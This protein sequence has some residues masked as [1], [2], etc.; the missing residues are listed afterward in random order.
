MTAKFRI[1]TPRACD[2]GRPI[3]A[4]LFSLPR[5]WPVCVLTSETS[6]SLPTRLRNHLQHPSTTY[7]LTPEPSKL[8]EDAVDVCIVGGGSAG[9][10]D[11][12]R[13]KPLK[14]ETGNETHSS[15]EWRT[16]YPDHPLARPVTSSGMRFLVEYY[17][18][19]I[20]HP[21][22]M[23]N[24]A[25]YITSPSSVVAWLGDIREEM[26]VEL[27]AKDAPGRCGDA[28]REA[29]APAHEG[30]ALPFRARATL[31][32][33]GVRASLS[34]HAVATRMYALKHEKV[35]QMYGMKEAWRVEEEKHVPGCTKHDSTSAP[36]LRTTPAS[37]TARALT[38]GGLPRL[39][40]PSGALVGCAAGV[41]N[42]AK[43]KGTHDAM[44]TRMLDTPSVTTYKE[45]VQRLQ[46]MRDIMRDIAKC[47]KEVE[48]IRTKTLRI[49]EAER[50]HQFS[51]GIQESREIIDGATTFS[52][53]RL[54]SA[55]R[56]GYQSAVTR[57]T[58]YESM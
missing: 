34:K 50:Q 8:E 3:P 7:D 55:R 45:F 17:L 37:P 40:F 22:Q 30:V 23:H 16:A 47:T 57:N 2:R 18:I 10:S 41:I 44:R 43:T 9:L 56:R 27:D 15:R 46:Y 49:V 48:E 4:F 32:A 31:L 19:L 25:N 1:T 53:A 21:P 54:T 5:C 26:G 13:L 14:S 24:K 20:P 39:D 58:S 12:I 11:A 6:R 51:A 29:D 42:T 36:S 35:A 38:R 52:F 33:E 28:R